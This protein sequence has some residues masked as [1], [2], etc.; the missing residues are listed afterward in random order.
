MP[1]RTREILEDL[2]AVRENLLALS[3]EIWQSIDQNDPDGL[4]EGVRFKRAYNEKMAAFDTLA[5]ELSAMI[6][7][8]T[9]VRLEEH[10]DIGGDDE[11]RNVRIIQA[12]NQEEPHSIDEDFT[13]KRPYGF[14]LDGQATT[15]ITTWRR[16]FELVC[17]QLQRRDPQR[18]A[19]LPENPDFISNRG[20]PTPMTNLGGLCLELLSGKGLE[21]AFLEGIGLKHETVLCH[22]GAVFP[23]TPMETR[24]VP[25]LHRLRLPPRGH[26]PNGHN[27]EPSVLSRSRVRCVSFSP[28]KSGNKSNTPPASTVAGTG[29]AGHC[30]PSS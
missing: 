8:F 20:H 7:Q 25:W 3:D 22:H 30:N 23:K 15:G 19:E 27:G 14:I 13:F 18:F 29:F 2:E 21:S 10:E 16:V 6:Q 17:Q 5:S 24:T 11:S 26:L 12:L 1:H 9:S 28:L 4:E